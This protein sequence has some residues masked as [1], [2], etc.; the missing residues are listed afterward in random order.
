MC[1]QTVVY[2][3]HSFVLTAG[4]LDCFGLRAVF[5]CSHIFFSA[6]CGPLVVPA[7]I[8]PEL[9]CLGDVSSADRPS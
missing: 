9:V 5:T 4:H 8:L 1:Q 7:E 3:V 6:I 2:C